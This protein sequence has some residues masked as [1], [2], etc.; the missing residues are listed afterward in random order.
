MMRIYTIIIGLVLPLV[1]IAG[2]P[3]QTKTNPMQFETKVI[4][5]RGGYSISEYV[6]SGFDNKAAI[7]KNYDERKNKKFMYSHFPVISQKLKVGRVT[8]TEASEVRNDIIS[9]PLFIIGYDPVSIDWLKANRGHLNKNKAIGLIVNV[10]SSKEMDHLQSIA[11]KN[12][13]LQPTPGD[14]L[15]EHLK[16]SHYPF[17]LDTNGVMR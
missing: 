3:N 1:L 4:A 17:Y 5:D 12:V 8:Y 7:K 9:E 10:K 16:I 13:R 6:P 14:D 11:G 2:E 15:A